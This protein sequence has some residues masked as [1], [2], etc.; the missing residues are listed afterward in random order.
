[1]DVS[2]RLQHVAAACTW[3]MLG[4]AFIGVL[5][6]GPHVTSTVTVN[7]AALLVGLG[8]A[9]LGAAVITAVSL[10]DLHNA[11]LHPTGLVG[12]I[13]RL[14]YLGG[15]TGVLIAGHGVQGPFWIL[16]LP[17]LLTTACIDVPWK[18]LSYA[19]AASG[20]TLLATGLTHGLTKTDA[21]SLLLILPALPAV[22][23]AT[24]T[25]AHSMS[26]V[27]GAA[28]AERV[29]Q[30]E[31]VEQFVADASPSAYEHL[32]ERL[33][34]SMDVVSREEFEAAKSMA[35]KARDENERLEKRI[36]ALEAHLGIVPPV[37]PGTDGGGGAAI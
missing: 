11:V 35:I 36:V 9:S 28:E 17:V 30:A 15:V 24:T 8:I 29:R 5:V 26:G 37:E 20:L 32:V 25:F 10:T 3:L 22:V 18:A 4:F 21:V 33:L 12:D 16:Y 31:E 6:V 23:A 1:V 2:K 34:A 7:Q 14:I 19:T 27:A 13:G